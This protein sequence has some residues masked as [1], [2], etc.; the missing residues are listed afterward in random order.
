M[1][2]RL[3]SFAAQALLAKEATYQ[4]QEA[5]VIRQAL[6]ALA[7]HQVLEL[8][9]EEIEEPFGLDANDLPTDPLAD[10]M[11]TNVAELLA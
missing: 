4:V 5:S 11:R 1:M 6:V 10:T 7:I 8:L 2:N 3:L 9:A